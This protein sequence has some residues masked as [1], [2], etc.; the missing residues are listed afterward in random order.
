MAPR[1]EKGEPKRRGNVYRYKFPDGT[2]FDIH[3]DEALSTAAVQLRALARTLGDDDPQRSE[4]LL[5]AGMYEQAARA[6][7]ARRTISEHN[8]SRQ[9]AGG[10]A[11]AE[12]RRSEK[13]RNVAKLQAEAN[14]IWADDPSLKIDYVAGV[15]AD[16]K[17]AGY[18]S[19]GVIASLI[20][21]PRKPRPLPPRSF[22]RKRR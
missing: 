14:K 5:K 19:R 20:E 16:R 22:S 4:L 12:Q 7:A 17:T 3:I 9:R 11:T 13:E 8:L 6:L 10:K 18:T 2:V 15:L 21:R 1:K